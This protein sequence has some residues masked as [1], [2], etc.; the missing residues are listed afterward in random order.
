MSNSIFHKRRT[1]VE[2]L[3]P[4]Y[5]IVVFC[6]TTHARSGLLESLLEM[7]LVIALCGVSRLSW[8]LPLEEST[9]YPEQSFPMYLLRYWLY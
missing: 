1:I 5:G 2:K 8:T 4:K 3:K 6:G 9:N 7:L